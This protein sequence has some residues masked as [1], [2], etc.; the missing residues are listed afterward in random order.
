MRQSRMAKAELSRKD[1]QAVSHLAGKHAQGRTQAGFTFDTLP[2]LA[3]SPGLDLYLYLVEIGNSLTLKYTVPAMA[4]KRWFAV[5][6]AASP[7]T[8]IPGK[9][10]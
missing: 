5:V 10:D 7:L 1:A 2:S 3:L 8:V 4:G 9:Q 6:M